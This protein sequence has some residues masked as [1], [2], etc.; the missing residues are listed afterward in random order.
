MNPLISVI[1]PVYNVE[2]YLDRCIESIVN[3]TYKNLEIILVDDG[4]TD[5]SGRKCDEWKVKDSRIIVIHKENGGLSDA[6]N[7]GMKKAIGDYIGFIDSDDFIATNM[8]QTLLDTAVKTDSEISE[9]QWLAF[10][11]EK[12]LDGNSVKNEEY[13][14][15]VLSTEEAL[16]ELII[17][18]KI[19]QTVVNK[20]YLRKLINEDFLVGRINED[21][22]WTYQII[23]KANRIVHI[24]VSLYFYYQRSTSIMHVKYSPKRLDGVEAR[25]R[26]MCFIKERFPHIYNYACL[27]FI[28]TCFYHY[29][30]ICRNDEID[31]DNHYRN[32]LYA[33]YCEH[34]S[35]DAFDSLPFKQKIWMSLFRYLPRLTCKIR[36]SL[37]IG[38]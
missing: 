30:V 37:C 11:N 2:D 35:K 1:V 25:R 29:Q 27:S 19:K 31:K 14:F 13:E 38:L 32:I 23:A 3:Q 12:E 18:R 10:E 20:L 5:S 28:W 16:K 34:Y 6:R 9:C 36:N 26:R 24:N 33:D 21:D 4:S 15:F 22:F 7:V 8:Y 17:E